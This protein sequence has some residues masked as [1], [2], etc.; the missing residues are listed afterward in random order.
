MTRP[1][2]SRFRSPSTSRHAGSR[3]MPRTPAL[4]MCTTVVAAT[5]SQAPFATAGSNFPSGS[6]AI[7]VKPGDTGTCALSPCLI[8]L[9]MPPG[10]GTYEVTANEI[11]IGKFPAG[12]AVNLGN[13][14]DSQAFAI[15]GADVKKA[16]V[17][18]LKGL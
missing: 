1:R 7:T 13:Y 4:L 16:Y 8:T 12:K 14:F 5:L 3:D 6:N 11:S 9:Q 10:N 18:I 17:Y 2:T 15:K